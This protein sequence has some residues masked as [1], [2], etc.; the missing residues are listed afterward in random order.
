MAF[1][2]NREFLD[3]LVKA[4]EAVR[5]EREVDWDL[6]AGA[7]VRRACETG[8]PAPFF[9]KI[10]DYPGHR[11]AG[12]SAASFRRV[13]IA[14]NLKPD[15]PVREIIDTFYRRSQKPIKP[16]LIKKGPCQQNVVTGDDVDLT[17]F[18]VPMVHDGDGGRYIG[19]WHLFTNKDPDTRWVNW[20]M[21][22]IMIHNERLVGALVL[23]HSDGF[24]IMTKYEA[25]GEGMPFAIAI[26]SDPLSTIAGA[27]TFGVGVDEVDMA[28]ALREEPVELVKCKTVDLEVPAYS[29]IVL[30]GHSIPDAMVDEGPFGE[31]TGFR[32]SPRHPRP[33]LRVECITW[34]DNPITMMSNMGMPVDESHVCSF[35]IAASVAFRKVLE[36]NRI[37][38]TGVYVPPEGCCWIVIVATKKPY[39]N[40]AAHIA[41][42]IASQPLGQINASKIIVVDDTVDP[43]NMT[44]V[45][46]AIGAKLHPLKGIFT[47]PSMGNSLAPYLSLEERAH[48]KGGKVVLDCTWPLEWDPEIEKPVKSAFN[49]I[50][51]EE[52]QKK[53][54]ENW[55]K[56]GYK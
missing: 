13:A 32:S 45:I 23:G 26:G 5:I 34:R 18:P 30:E 47:I 52:M 38:I 17:M 7:I 51:P 29:E 37:P 9:Q 46:H 56:Y 42:I 31:Y 16:I 41:S 15:T 39:E 12:A 11:M 27:S 14:M 3:A 28:G 35:G 55:Q 54:I 43:F 8:A 6:E 40:I 19:T 50:Y 25:K 4:G 48:G 2:D 22:R 53:V 10:R 49:T 36:A 21:Y 33:V 1:R 44:E 24:K 20:G